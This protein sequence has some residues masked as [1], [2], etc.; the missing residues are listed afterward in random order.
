M[1]WQSYFHH[2]DISLPVVR[3][4]TA[5]LLL[6]TIVWYG[7]VVRTG[8]RY[9]GWS[10][11]FPSRQSYYNAMRRLRK[12]GLIACKGRWD[13]QP[14][15]QLTERGERLTSAV[16][17]PRRLWNRKWS[18]IW[19]ALVYDVPEKRRDLRDALRG[20]LRRKRMG[21]LQRSVWVTPDDIRPDYDDLARTVDIQTVSFLFEARNVLGRSDEDIVLSSWDFSRLR[22]IHSWYR[23]VYEHNLHVVRSTD[24]APGALSQMASEELS[25][26]RSA[27]EEDPLLPR[28][29]LPNWYEGFKVFDLHISFVRSLRRRM[30]FLAKLWC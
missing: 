15:L 7:D 26:Y 6:E 14:V 9:L 11:C 25:A 30:G 2:P 10:H 8:G 22:D 18:G 21:C 3:R 16:L 24:M 28:S 29:L 13:R 5:E 27:M 19:Y 1:D 17:N 20:F 23:R 12:Q 4:R